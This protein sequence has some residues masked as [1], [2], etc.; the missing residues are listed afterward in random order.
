MEQQTNNKVKKSG[1]AIFM[2]CVI[3]ITFITSIICFT[4][5]YKN[6]HRN[7][8]ILWIGIVAFTIMYHLWVRI[9]MGNVSK[10]FKKHINYNKKWFKERKFEKGLYKLLRVKEWK[11]KALTYNPELYSLKDNSLEDIAN[12]MC[13]SEVDHW[14]NELISLSTLLFAIPWGNFGAFLITA[15]AAMIFDGQFIVIQRY[16]RPRVLN[17]IERRNKKSI[18]YKTKII[19]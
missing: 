7:T 3:A 10:L 19:I 1:P 12:T 5:Y 6:I 15:I 8:V 4:L 13:K 9:I 18:H 11:G 17:G 16:N 14:I 2:Y